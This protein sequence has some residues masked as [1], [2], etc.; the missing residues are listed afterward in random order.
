MCE[1]KKKWVWAE[2]LEAKSGVEKKEEIPEIEE[3]GGTFTRVADLLA[4]QVIV[5]IKRLEKIIQNK[6]ENK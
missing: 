3:E 5:E 6:N 2:D 1:K 4:N